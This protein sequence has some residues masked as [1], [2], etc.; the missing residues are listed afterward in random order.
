MAD[1][2]GCGCK[3]HVV[4]RISVVGDWPQ[5]MRSSVAGLV[6]LVAFIGACDASHLIGIGSDPDPMPD[7]MG[8][9]EPDAAMI[10]A[11]GDGSM[12]APSLVCSPDSWCWTHPLPKAIG[13]NSVW[14]IAA[15]DVW[16]VGIEGAILHHDGTYWAAVPSGVTSSLK[17]VWG[18]ASNDVWA[19]GDQ[20][21]LHWNG[22]VWT[23]TPITINLR[24]VWG[25]SSNDVWVAG[26]NS[27]NGSGG[28]LRHWDGAAWSAVTPSTY[29]QYSFTGLWG[30]SASDV[31][32]TSCEGVW[33]YDGTTWQLVAPGWLYAI[34]G[35]SPSDVYVV[36]S[37][38]YHWDGVTWTPVGTDEK[39][40]YSPEFTSVW[41]TGPNDVWASS[42]IKRMHWDGVA[43]SSLQLIE[44]PEVYIRQTWGTSP[45]NL[46]SVGDGGRIEHF[47]GTS[48]RDGSPVRHA[49]ERMW[50]ISD[51]DMWAVGGYDG[52]GDLMHWDGSRWTGTTKVA[53]DWL[54]G[55]W[56]SAPNDVW[57]VGDTKMLSHWDGTAWTPYTGGTNLNAVWGATSDD[58]WAVG[59]NAEIKHWDGASW[60]PDPSCMVQDP[61]YNCAIVGYYTKHLFDVWG[62]NANDVWAVG[63]GVILHR[64]NS[65]W[66]IT[67]SATDFWLTSLWGTSPSDVWAVGSRVDYAT[68]TKYSLA[69]H[70]NGTAWTSIPTGT[71][72]T[73]NAVGGTSSTDVWAVGEGGLILHWDGTA[74]AASR[75]GTLNDLYG[76]RATTAGVFVSG[77][78]GTVLAR[79]P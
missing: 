49:I 23:S 19:V 48:W 58:V 46:W 36:G 44:T 38:V 63:G 8:V 18:A 62:A 20:A 33:R 14:G 17:G 16:A 35:S 64:V 30:F 73:L 79:T 78:Q 6:A 37:N 29:A 67:Q 34:W 13:L 24:A 65:T 66:S 5:W 25:S 12:V 32:A 28:V 59:Y 53:G 22:T 10:D 55:V 45:T 70:W 57:V 69:L 41:G 1:P 42:A 9:V 15:D 75:S 72:V 31:W 27:T 77:A 54:H 4:T 76:V 56:A 60:S 74:W 7:A 2:T 51:N 11:P 47:D 50:S 3:V 43:W 52:V 68:S 26:A 61:G 39:P 21:L 40:L 71:N